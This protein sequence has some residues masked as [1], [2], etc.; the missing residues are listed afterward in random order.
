MKKSEESTRNI[1]VAGFVNPRRTEDGTGNTRRGKW[2]G[3]V[4][5]LLDYCRNFNSNIVIELRFSR[6]ETN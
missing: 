1:V 5:L 6:Y 3:M 2:L 4:D